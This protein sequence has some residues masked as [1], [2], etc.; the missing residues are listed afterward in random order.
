M[1]EK[2][3]VRLHRSERGQKSEGS[4]VRARLSAQLHVAASHT[5]SGLRG[6]GVPS[7][8]PTLLLAGTSSGVA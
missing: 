4:V 3:R 2:R 7:R 6:P 1:N 5:S 8:S